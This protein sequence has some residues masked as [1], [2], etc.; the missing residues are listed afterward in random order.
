MPSS[1]SPS[2]ATMRSPG[3][4]S[5]SA[6]GPCASRDITSTALRLLRPSARTRRRSSG[7]SRAAT[8]SQA[9]RTRPCVRISVSTHCAVAAGIAKPIPCAMAMIAVLMPTTRPRASTSGPPE[10]PGLSAAR[11]LHYALDEAPVAAAQRA[12]ERTDD[13]GRH[14][15]FEPEGVA[16]GDDQLPG[17]QAL[18]AGELGVGQRAAWA[19]STARSVAG[20][21][22]ATT[23]GTLR[24]STN[25]TRASLTRCTTCSLVSR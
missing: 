23:A 2:T 19:R 22:P 13:P 11:V 4:R 18:R 14:G 25:A 20:S 17:A 5:D 12:S 24:P 6:A 8:P 7:R 15:R 3:C 10:L 16:D 21:R 1:A 9:R